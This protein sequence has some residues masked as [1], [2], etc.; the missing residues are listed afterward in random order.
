VPSFN[1]HPGRITM[2]NEKLASAVT[3][4]G[5]AA[6]W[7]FIPLMGLIVFDV[8]GRR[9]LALPTIQLQEL[10]WYLHG[11][12]L[13]LTIGYAYLANAHV[14]IEAISELFPER[15]RLYVELF[16]ITIFLIPY[17]GLICY[18][19]ID[20]AWQAYVTGENSSAAQGLSDRWIIKSF[21]PIGFALVL[22]SG[23]VMFTRCRSGL[24]KINNDKKADL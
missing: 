23:V 6:C 20:F 2:L 7:L 5:R 15:V 11:I 19:S 12:L 9:F 1:A 8:V 22:L 21:L 24:R 16:G 18:L 10:Q 14:R 17:I 13:L 4:T 3:L